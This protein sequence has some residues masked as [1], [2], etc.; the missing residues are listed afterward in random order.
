MAICDQ[1]IISSEL[2][3]DILNIILINNVSIMNKD[4]GLPIR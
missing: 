4:L 2:G 1:D 3:P